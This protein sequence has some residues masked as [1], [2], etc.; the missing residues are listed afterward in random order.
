MYVTPVRFQQF[1][2]REDFYTTIAIYDDLAGTPINLSGTV[3]ANP[4]QAF[5]A[6]NWNVAVSG[7]VLTSTTSLTIPVPPINNQLL[8]VTLTV[9][10]GLNIAPGSPVTI[11]DAATGNNQMIGYVTGYTNSTGTLVCQIGYSFQ[12]EIRSDAP[13]GASAGYR[14][15]FDWGSP[16]D[17]GAILIAALGTGI[18]IIDIGYLQIF[19]PEITFKTILDQPYNSMSNTFSRTFMASMTIT[20]TINTRQ[21]F[22]GRLPILFGGVT[23]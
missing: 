14:P 3:L 6:S 1:T 8:A 22:I 20:D 4:S 11:S 7:N 16:N 19:I 23:L 13:T 9:P 10:A 21:L 5:T 12:F 18:S 15:Y 17:Q 2:N